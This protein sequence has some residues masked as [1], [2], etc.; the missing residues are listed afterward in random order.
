MLKY[1]IL[2]IKLSNKILQA[3]LN[4]VVFKKNDLLISLYSILNIDKIQN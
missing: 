1:K 4:Y 2:V 3:L